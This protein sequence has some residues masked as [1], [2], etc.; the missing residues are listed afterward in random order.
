[1]SASEV[2]PAPA[3]IASTVSKPEVASV[4][5]APALR[6]AEG[7]DATLSAVMS[8]GPQVDATS[9]VIS[10]TPSPQ[11]AP[12]AIPVA[13][14]PLQREITDATVLADPQQRQDVPPALPDRSTIVAPQVSVSLRAPEAEAA[15]VNLP[16]WSGKK[17]QTQFAKTL[18]D[19]GSDVV[20]TVAEQAPRKPS[21]DVVV[22]ASLSSSEYE[23]PT[24]SKLGSLTLAPRIG[25]RGTALVLP[26]KA[27][28]LPAVGGPV[29]RPKTL[30]AQLG[31]AGE[32]IERIALFTYAPSSV[33]KDVLDQKL[34]DLKTT[35]FP[36]AETSRV[37]FKVS[38]THIRYYTAADETVARAIAETVGGTARDFTR[39]KIT[40]PSGRIE[41]WMAGTRV[42][43]PPRA[44]PRVSTAQRRQAV[45]T[46]Q[47][48]RART[49]LK[50][51]LVDSLKRKEYLR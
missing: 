27:H 13:F 23:V 12:I 14:S 1:M 38:K 42:G 44:K 20:P 32:D 30:A 28:G 8:P 29:V 35:G 11:A 48:A 19:V 24:P 36:L 5:S 21:F 6:I 9:A 43:A 3:E 40:S 22:L 50:S 47:Q 15:P 10:F 18:F 33:T 51:R 31:A 26:E 2:V 4:S 41:I 49:Q 37:N 7:R 16:G 34:S 46:Q 45:Q 17:P 25:P 39:E